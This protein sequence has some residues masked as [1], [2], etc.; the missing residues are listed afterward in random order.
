MPRHFL[1][2]EALCETLELVFALELEAQPATQNPGRRRQP[3]TPIGSVAVDCSL[4]HDIQKVG[5]SLQLSTAHEAGEGLV[6]ADI[7]EGVHL[8]EGLAVCILAGN[9]LSI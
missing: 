4:A 3:Q 2:F 8:V 1:F 9:I 5:N 6:E 7:H